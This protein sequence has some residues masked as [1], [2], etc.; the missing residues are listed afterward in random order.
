[1]AVSI[2]LAASVA[3]A[4]EPVRANEGRIEAIEMVRAAGDH[5]VV[6]PRTVV[7]GLAGG[8]IGH[9]FGG[10]KGKT[11]ATV[12]GAVAGGVVGNQIDKKNAEATRYRI[13]IRMDSGSRLVIED[14]RDE[15]LRVGDRVQVDGSRVS[16]L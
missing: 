14:T 5:S 9:Q 4:G 7:G 6:N 3:L 12:A 16:R 13:V 8:V 10:G 2:S 15:N 1:V 11:A